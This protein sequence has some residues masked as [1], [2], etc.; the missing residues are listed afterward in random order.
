MKRNHKT[1][2]AV[3]ENNLILIKAFLFIFIFLLLSLAIQNTLDGLIYIDYPELGALNDALGSG[4]EIV[5]FGDSV[6]I[7][8]LENDTDNRTIGEMLEAE[9]GNGMRVHVAAHGA[10][11]QNLYGP[12]S[13]YIC[14]SANRPEIV[15]VPIN[16]ASFSA[17]W[18]LQPENQFKEEIAKLMYG[19]RAFL[20]LGIRFY[21]LFRLNQEE[22]QE[23]K[24]HWEEQLVYYNDTQ[25]GKIKD[26]QYTLL[27]SDPDIDY[28]AKNRYTYYYLYR[29]IPG[30]RQVV[31]LD[32]LI[33]N[34]NECGIRPILYLT[35][36]DLQSGSKYH[37]SNFTAIVGQNKEIIF[38]IGRQNNIQIADWSFA[39]NQSYFG[40]MFDPTEHLRQGGR[41][42][43]AR[44]L[45]EL[46]K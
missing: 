6:V 42:Y 43:V 12:F 19:D 15:V 38:D 30:H 18:D 39:L 20:N 9:L 4:A 25:I 5:Y 28:Q 45:A 13:E 31:S 22:L 10:Y 7:T 34:Y 14:R 8:P 1:T 36:I 24:I 21:Y 46:I 27:A 37:G 32:R 11:N 44:G 2:M 26:M 3:K 35:P 41:M 33:K 40:D 29:L 23:E 16:L 17:A